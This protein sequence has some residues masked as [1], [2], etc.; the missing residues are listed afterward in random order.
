MKIDKK[1]KLFEEVLEEAN[2]VG[3]KSCIVDILDFGLE[4]NLQNTTLPEVKSFSPESDLNEVKGNTIHELVDSFRSMVTNL[5]E[6]NGH[7]IN[8]AI[9]LNL[10]VYN[11][12]YDYYEEELSYE[13]MTPLAQ[14]DIDERVK[15]NNYINH[16]AKSLPNLIHE[17]KLKV[18]KVEQDEK[19]TIRKKIAELEAQL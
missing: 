16:T 10:S 6:A 3:D 5:I 14:E 19:A 2:L 15:R 11:T 1:D 13:V 8:E 18:E 7:S 4:A 9:N 17:Y 12:G